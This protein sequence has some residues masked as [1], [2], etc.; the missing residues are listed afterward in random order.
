MYIYIHVSQVRC[1]GEHNLCC[2][3]VFLAIVARMVLQRPENGGKMCD[4]D[5]VVTEASHRG[6]GG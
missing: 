6:S 1:F 2:V 3:H 5:L 4:G